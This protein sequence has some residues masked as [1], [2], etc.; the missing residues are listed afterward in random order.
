MKAAQSRAAT[1]RCDESS[2]VSVC[3]IDD[4]SQSYVPDPALVAEGKRRAQK[5]VPMTDEQW[6][7]WLKRVLSR[8]G[9]LALTP[10]CCVAFF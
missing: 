1:L 9:R 6:E 5:A 4:N 8:G 7:Q 10:D 2:S 3:S